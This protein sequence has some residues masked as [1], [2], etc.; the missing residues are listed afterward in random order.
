MQSHICK[1]VS[2]L[3]SFRAASCLASDFARPTEI[4]TSLRCMGTDTSSCQGAMPASK[5]GKPL[6]EHSTLNQHEISETYCSRSRAL[7]QPWTWRDN[8]SKRS[9]SLKLRSVFKIL[10]SFFWDLA[11]KEQSFAETE[12]F[13]HR[14]GCKPKLQV[15][16]GSLGRAEERCYATSFSQRRPGEAKLQ[17]AQLAAK[18]VHCDGLQACVAKV[19]AEAQKSSWQMSQ[20]RSHLCISEVFAASQR[21]LHGKAGSV[22]TECRQEIGRVCVLSVAC[23][24]AAQRKVAPQCSIHGSIVVVLPVWRLIQGLCSCPWAG[25]AVQD[26]RLVFLPGSLGNLNADSESVLQ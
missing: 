4:H 6:R 8:S 25:N 17:C 16:Q 5:I 24:E 20:E 3:W 7:G 9:F 23:I 18:A 14:Q 15:E 10:R 1:S 13:K 2:R 11:G 26:S 19:Q 12:L 22:R 21:E